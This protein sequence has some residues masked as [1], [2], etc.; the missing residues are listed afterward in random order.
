MTIN[1]VDRLRGRIARG[2][3]CVGTGITFTDPAISE[4]VGDAGYDFT[5]IDMEHCPIDLA[6]ALGHVM[7]VRGT[8]AAPLIRVRCGD[9]DVIKP[10]L[11]LHPAGIIAPQVRSVADVERVVGACKYP[12]VG[13]RGF[14]PRRGRRFG[15]TP[16]PEYLQDADAQILVFVQIEHIDAVRALDG[17]LQVA[18]LDGVCLGFNDLAGS[19]GL[20]GQ[21]TDPRVMEVAD[22]VIRQTR[23]TDKWM[24]I[25]MGWQPAAVKEWIAK[26]VQWISLGGDYNSLYTY[27]R[28]VLDEVRSWGT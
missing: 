9:P 7:A 8:G 2:E 3:L 5:W 23:A 14:G 28:G 6:T 25:S 20:S 24:G 13:T 11:E 19:M 10:V 22:E 21:V 17:I 16:Y 26:G 27:S 15:G 18:G 12:P 4:L 1:H